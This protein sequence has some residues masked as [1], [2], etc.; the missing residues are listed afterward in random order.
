MNI[1]QLNSSA[2]SIGSR[3]TKLANDIVAK[4]RV[5][6]VSREP[7][8]ALDEPARQALFTAPAHR[9]PEQA[10]RVALND[11]L[12]AEV[13]AADIVVLGVPRYN[14]GGPA[15]LK[16]WIDVLARA[17]DIPLYRKRAAGLRQGR[18]SMSR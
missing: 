12:I 17:G 15:S 4:L 1:L 18:P 6:D 16:N 13:Q 5:R 7:V 8:P 9:S 3:S 14:V 2:R 10:A 11:A